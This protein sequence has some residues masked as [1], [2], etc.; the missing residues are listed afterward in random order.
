MVDMKVCLS[1]TRADDDDGG[2]RGAAI[3]T[4]FAPC[5]ERLS[6]RKASVSGRKRERVRKE[7][8]RR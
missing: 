2:C 7:G 8:R 3:A 5:G 6:R 4:A 1:R